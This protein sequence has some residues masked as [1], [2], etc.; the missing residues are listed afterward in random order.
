MQILK[1]AGRRLMSSVPTLLI[2]L[3]GLFIL[4]Q[5]AP[6]DTVDALMAQM[7]GGDPAQAAELRRFYGLEG[8]AAVRLLDYLWRLVRLDLGFTAIWVTPPV[9]N[10]SG[11]DYHGYHL[12]C[13]RGLPPT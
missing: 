13:E 8:S 6:G 4:L 10:R 1:L 11:L 12:K 7:G 3:A 9:E 5:F 2:L